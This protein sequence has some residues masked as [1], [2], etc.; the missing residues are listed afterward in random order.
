MMIEQLSLCTL[1]LAL[2]MTYAIILTY[3][4]LIE[5]NLVKAIIY[6][7]GQAIAYTL[8]LML[9]AA[10][11]LVLAYVAVGVGMY[12]ALFLFVVS[13]TEDRE[14]ESIEE[15]IKAREVDLNG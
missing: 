10:P 3:K 2:F 1:L 6:S 5:T 8:A 11:D 4:T 13:R 12:T 9:L 15:A 14:Y 7:A